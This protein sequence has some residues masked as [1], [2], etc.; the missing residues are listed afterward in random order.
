VKAAF[1]QRFAFAG[2]NK[3]HGLFGGRMA[4]F[5]RYDPVGSEVHFFGFSD[6]ADFRLGSN[7]NWFNQTEFSGFN[8]SQQ[9]IVIAGMRN[10]AFD[11]C[12]FSQRLS[13]SAYLSVLRRMTC[14]VARLE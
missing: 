12:S 9:R 6:G 3:R 8:R 14:G 2:A 13:N 7:Q 1:H 10:D 5:R 4:V 11:R